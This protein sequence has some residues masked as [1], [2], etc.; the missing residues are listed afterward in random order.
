MKRDTPRGPEYARSRGFL[1][2]LSMTLVRIP[3][4]FLFFLVMLTCRNPGW[5]LALSF[6]LLAAIEFTDAFDGKIARKYGLVTEYGAAVDPF[7]DSVSRI[8]VYWA[9]AQ[10]GLVLS[11]LPLVMAVRDVT[12]AYSRIVLAQKRR[13]V[14]AKTSGKIKAIVQASG[15]FLALL[16]PYY[17]NPVGYWSYYALSWM[18]VVVTA[19][20]A[21]EYVKD[22]LSSFKEDIL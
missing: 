17:W 20:S 10:R 22:A 21:V 14:S 15:S 9:L 3:L 2:V 19:F 7:A 8:V 1:G 4:S 13:S 18:I 11:L 12:V 5:T 6:F 16:G